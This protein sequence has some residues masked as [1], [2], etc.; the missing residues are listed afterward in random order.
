MSC[1]VNVWHMNDLASGSFSDLQD[2][3]QHFTDVAEAEDLK[4]RAHTLRQC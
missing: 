3:C 4:S 1:M 2:F